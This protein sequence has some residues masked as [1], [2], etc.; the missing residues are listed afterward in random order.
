LDVIETSII[1]ILET[2]SLNDM[3]NSMCAMQMN[4]GMSKQVRSGLAGRVKAA[5]A[6]EECKY[7]EVPE[8]AYEG[9]LKGTPLAPLS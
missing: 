5:L 8:D 1:R 4:T 2:I 9:E 3:A 7:R 6:S